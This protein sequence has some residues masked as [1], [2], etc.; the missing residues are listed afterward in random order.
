MSDA[1]QS[2]YETEP[3]DAFADEDRAALESIGTLLTFQD[4]DIVYEPGTASDG[5]YVLVDGCVAL[6]DPKLTGGPVSF[7]DHGTVVSRGSLLT[8]FDHRHLCR[9]QG[10]TTLLFVPRDAFQE[11]FAAGEMFALLLLDYVVRQASSEVRKLNA[12]IHSLLS[13]R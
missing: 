12:A 10:R 1:L 5:A 13:G 3:F 6:S 4:G 2:I 11:R 8:G 7:T 9:A